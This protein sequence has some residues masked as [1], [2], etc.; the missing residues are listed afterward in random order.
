MHTQRCSRDNQEFFGKYKQKTTGEFILHI[1]RG[2][3]NAA[4]N[5][6]QRRVFH[7]HRF[8]DSKATEMDV[9]SFL[10]VKTNREMLISCP[11]SSHVY[12]KKYFGRNL[13]VANFLARIRKMFLE[14]EKGVLYEEDGT[15]DPRFEDMPENHRLYTYEADSIHFAL[16]IF[17]QILHVSPTNLGEFLEKCGVETKKYNS[18]GQNIITCPPKP[19][20]ELIKREF[21]LFSTSSE[22]WYET[23]RTKWRPY[24]GIYGG[25]ISP[26]LAARFASSNSV[27]QPF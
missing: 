12:T 14:K 23:M 9:F 24:C 13:P 8:F 22:T 16:Q 6:N 1:R 11:D 17:A 4:P 7:T 10:T 19:Q 18:K 20:T 26:Q 15:Y 27:R 3:Q 5:N 25:G 21:G 2:W